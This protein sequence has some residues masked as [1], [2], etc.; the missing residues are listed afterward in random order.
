MSWNTAN[1]DNSTLARAQKP[2]SGSIKA[3]RKHNNL[4]FLQQSKEGYWLGA[5]YTNQENKFLKR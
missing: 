1:L 5:A 3:D 4:E 2:L